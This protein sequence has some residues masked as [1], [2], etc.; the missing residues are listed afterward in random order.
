M[1]NVENNQFRYEYPYQKDASASFFVW[2]TG[3]EESHCILLA[4]CHSAEV[5]FPLFLN[6]RGAC[7]E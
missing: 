3:R 4:K 6:G 2:V 1:D 7:A 5:A